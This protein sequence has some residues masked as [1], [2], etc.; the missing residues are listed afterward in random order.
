MYNIMQLFM[1]NMLHWHPLINDKDIWTKQNIEVYVSSP[2]YN[3]LIETYITVQSCYIKFVHKL[4]ELSSLL[5]LFQNPI[6]PF[7][8]VILLFYFWFVSAIISDISCHLHYPAPS[9]GNQ[10]MKLGHSNQWSLE[11]A[12]LYLHVLC[13]IME[14]YYLPFML[15]S[16]C[17]LIMLIMWC[18][19]SSFTS[20]NKLHKFMDF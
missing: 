19:N 1:S 10:I 16:A 15:L 5:P 14:E 4:L 20:L 17:F 11:Y 6:S 13:T 12:D 3:N 8:V 18:N 2:C 9:L 7:R